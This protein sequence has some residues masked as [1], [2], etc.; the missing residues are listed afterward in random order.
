M[1]SST[2]TKRKPTPARTR[3][4][5]VAEAKRQFVAAVRYPDG[6]SE[7]FHILNALNLAD[8]RELVELEVGDVAALVIA[9][10]GIV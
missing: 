3:H 10:R 1:M 6:R 5:P 4:Q 8:A 7:L 9:E 2:Q